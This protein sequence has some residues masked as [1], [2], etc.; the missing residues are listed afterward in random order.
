MKCSTCERHFIPFNG[1]KTC[2]ICR[3]KHAKRMRDNRAANKK[4]KLCPRCGGQLVNQNFK[5]CF[6][7]RKITAERKRNARQRS[8]QSESLQITSERN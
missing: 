8:N 1:E 2:A 6:K 4:A 3:N 5:E 7:C